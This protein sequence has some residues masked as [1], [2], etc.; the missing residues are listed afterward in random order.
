MPRFKYVGSHAAVDIPAL[1]ATVLRGDVVEADDSVG[2]AD[3]PDVWERVAT[4]K[5]EK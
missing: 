4:T 2:L 1:G 3:Q 5:K